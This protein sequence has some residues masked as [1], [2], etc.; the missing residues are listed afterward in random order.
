VYPHIVEVRLQPTRA[1]G[2]A[3]ASAPDLREVTPFD[4]VL[5]F[6]EAAEGAPP[7][8]AMSELLREVV[9][10]CVRRVES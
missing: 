6:W 9:E 3:E 5:Q 4:A 7:D 2:E 10:V 1:E 8:D